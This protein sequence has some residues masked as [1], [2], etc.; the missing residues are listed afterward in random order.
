MGE[1]PG[2]LPALLAVVV[3]AGVLLLRL[4]SQAP[5][6]RARERARVVVERTARDAL[7]A[8]QAGLVAAAESAR[9]EL[10]ATRAEL[11][12]LEPERQRLADVRGQY[13]IATAALEGLQAEIQRTRALVEEAT[14]DLARHQAMRAEAEQALRTA[15]AAL[16]GG[17][18]DASAHAHPA[19]AAGP[20]AARPA[21]S[22]RVLDLDAIATGVAAR[23]PEEALAGVVRAVRASAALPDETLDERGA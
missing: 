9:Q 10:V 3:I 11:A 4:R 1:L 22:V 14:A 6:Q 17:A 15:R 23:D 19:E 8:E 12:E 2:I 18:P 16:I 5:A 20:A 13:A 21:R 7:V